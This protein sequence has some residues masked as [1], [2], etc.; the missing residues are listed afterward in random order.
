MG[1][2]GE[3]RYIAFLG[4]DRAKNGCW[5]RISE[6]LLGQSLIG[7]RGK[8]IRNLKVKRQCSILQGVLNR[9]FLQNLPRMC[10]GSVAFPF[11]F[12]ERAPGN[13]SLR[14]S[15]ETSSQPHI[16][17]TVSL[18]TYIDF[19]VWSRDDINGRPIV[20]TKE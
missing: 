2:W 17:P 14:W 9:S 8:L 5:N 19:L 10:R 15:R 16:L 20:P 3:L 18:P 13:R 12:G 4:N 6:L 11:F 7:V 1:Y